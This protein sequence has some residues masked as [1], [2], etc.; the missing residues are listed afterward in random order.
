MRPVLA[1]LVVREPARGDV[2]RVASTAE[3][4]A[5]RGAGGMPG[6]RE[7]GSWIDAHVPPGAKFMTIGPS[8]ANLLAFYGRREACGLSVSPNPLN[9]NPSYE[10]IVNPDQAL[11]AGDIQYVVWDTFSASRVAGFS[12]PPAAATPSATTGASCTPSC[13]RR[14][15]PDGHTVRSPAIVVYD[16]RP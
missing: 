11:R 5:A 12:R 8:M 7:A 6:G 2:G 13:S 16:V 1:A 15:P 3:R 4:T 10:P 14:A 9:R